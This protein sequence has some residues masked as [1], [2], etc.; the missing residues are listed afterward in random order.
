MHL[1]LINAH[2]CAFIFLKAIFILIPRFTCAALILNAHGSYLHFFLFINLS[3]V[4][5]DQ[6]L[7]LVL[8]SFPFE[9]FLPKS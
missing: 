2:A 1:L 8:R 9:I 5:C 3:L 6:L 7:F 4:V